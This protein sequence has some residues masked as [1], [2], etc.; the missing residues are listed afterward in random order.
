LLNAT[1]NY[2]QR[3]LLIVKYPILALAKHP[4]YSHLASGELMMLLKQAFLT[5]WMVLVGT[6]M[7]QARSRML[8]VSDCL[9]GDGALKVIITLAASH[10]YCDV[11]PQI[12][13]PL[14]ARPI[15]PDDCLHT[16][17]AAAISFE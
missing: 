15:I 6:P 3:L 13:L 7:M 17:L 2:D 4:M 10:F 9:L 14:Q 5:Q 16:N 11:F 12:M 1:I 8:G